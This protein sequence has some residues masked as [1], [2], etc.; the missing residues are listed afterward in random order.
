MKDKLTQPVRLFFAAQMGGTRSSEMA[1]QVLWLLQSALSNNPGPMLTKCSLDWNLWSL[2]KPVD[3]HLYCQ[4]EG[5][6]N[7]MEF[8][9][10][11]IRMEEDSP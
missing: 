4:A 2:K 9:S 8:V 5:S 7:E 1:N 11:L 6:G 3:Q 10:S